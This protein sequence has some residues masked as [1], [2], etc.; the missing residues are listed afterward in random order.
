M[1]KP[2]YEI[3]D[4]EFKN[5]AVLT[6]IGEIFIVLVIL[7]LIVFLGYTFYVW[8][9]KNFFK[10]APSLE[11]VENADLKGDH[12]DSSDDENGKPGE[13]IMETFKGLSQK[14]RD[15]EFQNN[16]SIIAGSR[17]DGSV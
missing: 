10:K 5:K 4:Y 1:S 17:S 11:D 8:M 6:K 3:Q 2:E 14:N 7:S 12:S 9:R 16:N 15:V 13:N